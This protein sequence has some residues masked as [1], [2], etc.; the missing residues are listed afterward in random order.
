MSVTQQ[1]WARPLKQLENGKTQ[2]L[3]IGGEIQ[4]L[5]Q[6]ALRILDLESTSLEELDP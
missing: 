2:L 6:N 5:A 1:R 3:G 4:G